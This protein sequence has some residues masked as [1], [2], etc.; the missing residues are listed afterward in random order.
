MNISSAFGSLPIRALSL[1]IGGIMAFGATAHAATQETGTAS[2]VDLLGT[3]DNLDIMVMRGD[4]SEL[5]VSIDGG[6]TWESR[7]FADSD[8]PQFEV[9]NS[10][11]PDELETLIESLRGD[12]QRLV[13]RGVF[14]AHDVEQ[15]IAEMES[16]LAESRQN[17]DT[18]INWN[19]TWSN[20]MEGSSMIR[21]NG[22]LRLTPG[23]DG[24]WHLDGADD[25]PMIGLGGIDLHQ[26]GSG[27]PI[28]LNDILEGI[29]IHGFGVIESREDVL[30]LL[31]TAGLLTP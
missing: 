26:V 12:T 1:A 6:Q 25:V 13:E 15:M 18:E 21:T 30:D 14:S 11:T 7:Q 9:K 19:P 3:I 28:D 4:Q 22:L 31:A 29:E 23:D 8:F 17:G 27:A 20:G 24:I 2:A 10:F 5:Q 16:L